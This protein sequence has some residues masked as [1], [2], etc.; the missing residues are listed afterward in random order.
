MHISN[1]SFTEQQVA[2]IAIAV[3]FLLVRC[4]KSYTVDKVEQYHSPVSVSYEEH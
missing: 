1:A 3:G 4:I 2:C